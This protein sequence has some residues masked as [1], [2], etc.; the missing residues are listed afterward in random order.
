MTLSFVLG[1][2]VNNEKLRTQIL[3][4]VFSLFFTA[5][6]AV[7]NMLP[8]SCRCLR[9]EQLEQRCEQ[10]EQQEAE[11]TNNATI[12]C[13]LALFHSLACSGQHVTIVHS[14]VL[15]N[16]GNNNKKQRTQTM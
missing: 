7:R 1:N 8:L 13:V 5:Y 14:V 6:H 15:G 10:L 16:N 4:G 3:K 9:Q 2:N 12:R 11:D